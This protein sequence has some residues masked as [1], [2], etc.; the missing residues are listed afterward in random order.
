[1]VIINFVALIFFKIVCNAKI[2]NLVKQCE[3]SIVDVF[4]YIYDEL[5]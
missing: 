5:K 4:I 1:M 2:N 3:Y